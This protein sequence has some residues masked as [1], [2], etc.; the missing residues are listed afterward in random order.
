[1]IKKGREL[2]LF[3]AFLFVYFGVPYAVNRPL[4]GILHHHHQFVEILFRRFIIQPASL[5]IRST[6]N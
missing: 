1:M 5:R 4:P 3:T 6:H 2:C